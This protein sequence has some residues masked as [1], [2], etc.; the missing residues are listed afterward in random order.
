M[1]GR[2]KTQNFPFVSRTY[3]GSFM[4]NSM[5]NAKLLMSIHTLLSTSVYFSVLF[6]NRE[7]KICALSAG[8]ICLSLCSH[9]S[10][11]MCRI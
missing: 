10:E 5:E 2:D 1:K 4:I 8:N 7:R 11:F 9:T 3:N 6:L